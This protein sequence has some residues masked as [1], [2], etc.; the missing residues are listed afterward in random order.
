MMSNVKKNGG[1]VIMVL[2]VL[3]MVIQLIPATVTQAAD[4]NKAIIEVDSYIMYGGGV[5][6]TSA[7]PSG[8]Q[9]RYV[10][11][12]TF[13]PLGSGLSYNSPTI[14]VIVPADAVIDELDY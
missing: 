10:F 14:T 13:Y 1:R 5:S 11:D 3:L 2:L 8:D 4:D 9:F 12:Y 6:S 7:I